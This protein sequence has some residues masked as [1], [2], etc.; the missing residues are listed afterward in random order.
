MS[1][2]LIDFISGLAERAGVDITDE[3]LKGILTNPALASIEV[4]ATLETA[5]QGKLITEDE[6]RINPNLKKYFSAMA[7]NVAD[8]NLR[9]M[10]EKYLD[11]DDLAD[12]KRDE[13]KTAEIAQLIVEKVKQK[14]AGADNAGDKK[15][16]LAEITKLQGIIAEKEA[17]A[18]QAV[19]E[20]DKYWNQT[21]TNKELEGLFLGYDYAMDVPKEIAAATARNL[22]EARLRESG[23]KY[24]YDNGTIKLVNSESEDLPFSVNNKQVTAKQFADSIVEPLVKKHNPAP[25]PT[26]TPNPQILKPVNNK[27]KEIAMQNLKELQESGAM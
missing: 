4:P 8:K 16:Y 21:L 22:F 15:T 9:A 18:M 5:V 2:N 23:G 11:A 7:L 14:S 25:A 26:P 24:V 17:A 6:A 3:S 10:A 1:L 27:A 19:A 20:R 13:L 12:I